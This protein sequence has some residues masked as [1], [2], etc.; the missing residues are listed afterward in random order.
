MQIL[1]N[2]YSSTFD[3]QQWFFSTSE[4]LDC[5]IY[6]PPHLTHLKKLKAEKFEQLKGN[7]NFFFGGIIF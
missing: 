4:Y 2:L 6:I 1:I 3:V 7:E 5:F